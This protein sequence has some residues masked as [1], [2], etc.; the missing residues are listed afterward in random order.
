LTTTVAGPSQIIVETFVANV[1]EMLTTFSMS[2]TM[3][4]HWTYCYTD[5]HSEPEFAPYSQSHDKHVYPPYNENFPTDTTAEPSSSAA[6]TA[7]ID[8]ASILGIDN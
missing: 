4:L 7:S 3:D 1:T 8:V 2:T 6:P 5:V